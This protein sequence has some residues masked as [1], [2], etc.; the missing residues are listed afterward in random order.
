MAEK[1][2]STVEITVGE[3]TGDSGDEFAL[4]VGENEVVITVVNGQDTQTYTITLTR[5]ADCTLSALTIGSLILEPAFDKDVLEYTTTT[6][7][8]TNTVTATPTSED[9]T[10]TIL[11]GETPVESGS[12]ATWEEGENI[13]SIEVANGEESQTYTV[14]VTKE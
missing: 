1:E 14:T 3:V 2:G 11:N 8:A 12:A 6:T 4:E 7:N 13:L 10:V 9:A 5:E